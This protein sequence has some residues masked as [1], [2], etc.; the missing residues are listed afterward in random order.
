MT[1]QFSAHDPVTRTD[2]VTFGQTVRV[3]RL[4]QGWTQDELADAAG[5]DRQTVSRIENAT[6]AT[7]MPTLFRLARALRI[8]PA[9]L[10]ADKPPDLPPLRTT[11]HR[12]R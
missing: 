6:Y 2:L 12:P 11:G 1:R 4:A 9:A 7:D 5:I 8:P 3:Y 10:V